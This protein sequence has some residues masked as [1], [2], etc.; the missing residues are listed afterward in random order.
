MMEEDLQTGAQEVRSQLFTSDVA[1]EDS[2]F[3]PDV[4]MEIDEAEVSSEQDLANL[5]ELR[6]I[7]ARKPEHDPDKGEILLNEDSLNR[8]ME[9][10][11]MLNTQTNP[12]ATFTVLTDALLNWLAEHQLE[13]TDELFVT[14]WNSC[15]KHKHAAKPFENAFVVF[16]HQRQ[17]LGPLFD[18]MFEVFP[19][20]TELHS[21]AFRAA[22]E[23]DDWESA[24]YIHAEA[25]AGRPPGVHEETEFII[26]RACEGSMTDGHRGKILNVTNWARKLPG[27]ISAVGSLELDAEDQENG[28]RFAFASAVCRFVAAE[29]TQRLL[30]AA[31]L[32]KRD[33][34]RLDKRS[35]THKFRLAALH[36]QDQRIG[37]FTT[38]TQD[39]MGFI[40]LVSPG[41]VGSS[42]AEEMM[43]N[44]LSIPG[45]EEDILTYRLVAS[46]YRSYRDLPEAFPSQ[47][48]LQLLLER[49]L[50]WESN[51]ARSKENLLP[52]DM[53][54]YDWERLH[55]KLSSTAYIKI[56]RVYA[57]IGEAELVARWFGEFKRTYPDF[58]TYATAL[59]CTVEV[60]AH[61]ANVAGAAAAFQELARDA[62]AHNSLPHFAC[63]TSL[64]RTYARAEDVSG[65]MDAFQ[66]MNDA[67]ERDPRF[68]PNAYVYH[69]ICN[70]LAK[71]GDVENVRALL[72]QFDVNTK[73]Q[74]TTPL[75]GAE[76]LALINDDR[77]T[78]AREV[79]LN[80]VEQE[81][82]GEIVGAHTKNFNLVLT[83]Y[84]EARDLPGAVRLYKEMKEAQV[85]PNSET[86][87][88]LIL[89]LSVTR[90]DDAAF[91]VIR[92][93]MPKE[94]FMP[95]ALH[96]GIVMQGYLH[97]K[98]WQKV[99][100]AHGIMKSMNVR[101][102]AK[103][104]DIYLTARSHVE[105]TTVAKNA[106]KKA[107]DQRRNPF[108]PPPGRGKGRGPSDLVGFRHSPAPP[109][110]A[111]VQLFD[112]ESPKS[113]KW[114]RR[115][116][117][118]LLKRA[119]PAEEDALS[120]RFEH[121]DKKLSAKAKVKKL[122]APEPT[123]QDA[124]PVETKQLV[125]EN[126]ATD[127]QA[128][129]H[130]IS[131][132]QRPSR[133]K[134]QPPQ[135]KSQVHEPPTKSN[136]R[137]LRTKAKAK[138]R[139]AQQDALPVETKQFARVLSATDVQ[140]PGDGTSE[141]QR[142]GRTKEQ[143]LQKKP[144]VH[145]PPTQSTLRRMRTIGKKIEAQLLDEYLIETV[146]DF[147]D[148]LPFA[149]SELLSSTRSQNKEF[150]HTA[151]QYLDH[152]LKVY[153][154]ER[155][156]E[157]VR[158]LFDRY[159]ARGV[160]PPIA[161][162]AYLMRTLHDLKQYKEVDL[163]WTLAKDQADRMV[164]PVTL[165][166]LRPPAERAAERAAER[167]AERAAAQ[168]TAP[169]VNALSI[170]APQPPEK[171]DSQLETAPD[172]VFGRRL[173][174]SRPALFYINTLAATNRISDA[175][176]LVTT[177][178]SEGYNLDNMT[179][180]SFIRHL[181][182]ADPPFALLAFQLTERFLILNFPGWHT[183]FWEYPNTQDKVEGMQHIKA[184]Y[185]RPG[186][187]VPQYQ[188]IIFL[189]HALLTLRHYEIQGMEYLESEHLQVDGVNLARYVG[190]LK[191]IRE[192]AP[193]TLY[194][195]QSMPQLDDEW[196]RELRHEEGNKG[197]LFTR[198]SAGNKD[199]GRAEEGDDVNGA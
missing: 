26:F 23:A 43:M 3:M 193:R 136:L 149:Q 60:H 18:A 5:R 121:L 124:L 129:G 133:A 34:Y 195:V 139:K 77:L 96:F 1:G 40:L 10:F 90:H 199:D 71:K 68:T 131:E 120:G 48:L 130:G 163:C 64:I 41:R 119:E 21:L 128:P 198:V 187:L 4:P 95:T 86:F 75:I 161:I 35:T 52:L 143:P 162:L 55:Q 153:G 148:L 134:K 78:E 171:A 194:A 140:A 110:P 107:R 8:A 79:L 190:R 104:E 183:S 175:I 39:L 118:D 127:V 188:T 74:R 167:V 155:T 181:C 83:G 172:P 62:A 63:W 66:A 113:E 112:G 166:D 36:R 177:L 184:R 105:T 69:T 89:A 144:K 73:T 84:A 58:R 185:L 27:P 67:A 197:R 182:G 88:A 106:A 137:R 191:Q 164:A 47:D 159:F 59:S 92:F 111:E 138:M 56:I 15:R 97:I 147:E 72:E 122:K 101:P 160:D 25:L 42:F 180:N 165:P 100:W 11:N 178:I 125:G 32:L 44:M 93:E 99:I 103:T 9:L 142:P 50:R 145:G 17:P 141:P 114:P 176:T 81:Q 135:K 169:E 2:P 24:F 173:M 22:F 45:K 51:T 49:S 46:F 196:Q 28:P 117:A 91:A 61:S 14:V 57:D 65:A 94:G 150:G 123:Q 154:A 179:W 116:K 186:H 20:Y 19:S 85:P 98:N 38:F 13:N 126:S 157:A 115:A 151:K 76:I 29:V 170:K 189:S 6:R 82:R 31:L 102:N 53:I 132:P 87:G 70:L 108:P 158:D 30:G 146:K 37:A 16:Q 7:V 152:S 54:I 156:L 80:S 168:A 174:L 12:P 33:D 109:S 192:N